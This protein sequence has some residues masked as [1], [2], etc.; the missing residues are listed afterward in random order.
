MKR[1]FIVTGGAGLIGSNIVQT[2]NQM[3]ETDILIVDHLG[4]SEKWKNLL[5]LTYRDYIE[6]DDFMMR[7]ERNSQFRKVTHIIH[8][9]ACSSTTE[10]DATYL[11][12]NNFEYTKTLCEFALQNEM[13]FAYASSAATYG[14]GANGYDDKAEIKQLRP[15]NMYGYSKHLF[16][17]YAETKK[18]TNKIIGL[19]YFNVFGYGEAHK[20]DM[21]SVV[22]KG[23]EQIKAEG[24]MNLFKSYHPGYADGEQKRDFL[25]VKDAAKITLHLLFGNH[26]GLYNIGRGVAETWKDLVSAIFKALDK[27]PSINFIDMP[28]YL[29]PK[30]QYYTKAETEKLLNTGYTEGFTSLEDAVYEYVKL[31]EG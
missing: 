25:Y 10:K 3:G 30:Y 8:M 19:K 18:L 12:R 11:I 26:N 4:Q 17:L 29:K 16:D 13:K 27:E 15:L 14:D 24:S 7:L 5:N 6:K 22:L 21:R 28:D 23:Y 31:L 1:R 20:G 9:G 2:L